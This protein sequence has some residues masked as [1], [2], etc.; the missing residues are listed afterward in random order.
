[1]KMTVYQ[2]LQTM[3]VEKLKEADILKG[4]TKRD[5]EIYYFYTCQLKI[6]EA[7]SDGKAQSITNTSD[8]YSLSERQIYNILDKMEKKV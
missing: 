4:T 6:N 3:D 8:K 2:L 1:L 5:I 7:A